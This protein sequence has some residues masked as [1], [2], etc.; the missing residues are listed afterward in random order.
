MQLCNY[1][2]V[3]LCSNAPKCSNALF[4][5]SS[6]YYQNRAET[7]RVLNSEARKLSSSYVKM[8]CVLQ[9]KQRVNCIKKI[10]NPLGVRLTWGSQVPNESDSE[11]EE[12]HKLREFRSPRHAWDI[13]HSNV[14]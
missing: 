9:L 8:S 13:L 7:L 14:L 6:L 4:L 11:D 12:P 2:K 10:I 5:G 1:F 3:L